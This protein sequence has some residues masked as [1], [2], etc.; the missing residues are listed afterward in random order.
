[1]L[2][3]ETKFWSYCQK[4]HFER[5]DKID[6]KRNFST[7]SDGLTMW[8]IPLHAFPLATIHWCRTVTLCKEPRLENRLSNCTSSI[9]TI[10]H[11]TW[12]AWE[13]REVLE[14]CHRVVKCVN[15]IVSVFQRNSIIKCISRGWEAKK[16]IEKN[17]NIILRFL[18]STL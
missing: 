6:E 2:L 15:N 9:W 5:I 1:M 3:L 13:L 17:R 11:V 8:Y 12:L 16:R 7:S 4:K 10:G 14:A 18:D